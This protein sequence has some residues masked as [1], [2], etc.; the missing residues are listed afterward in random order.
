MANI[1]KLVAKIKRTKYGHKF[2]DLE[3]ILFAKGYQLSKNKGSH[4]TYKSPTTKNRIT[5]AKHKP[6]SPQAVQDVITIWEEGL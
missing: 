3:K 4:F 2:E 5:L 6:M 1:E